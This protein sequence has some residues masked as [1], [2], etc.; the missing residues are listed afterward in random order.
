MDQDKLAKS[1]AIYDRALDSVELAED[2]LQKSLIQIKRF[3]TK[4]TFERTTG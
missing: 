2:N 3:A 1:I 4:S